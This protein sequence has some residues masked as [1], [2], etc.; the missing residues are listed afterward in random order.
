MMF[1]ITDL[2]ARQAKHPHDIFL[3]NLI[4]NHILAFAGLLGMASS[5]PWVMIITPTVSLS[6]LIYLVIRSRISLQ[7]DDWFVMC[8][9]QLCARRS[10]FFIAMLSIL[11]ALL[12][13]LLASVGWVLDDMKPGHWAIMGI[14]L[15]PTLISVLVL[16]VME[17]DAQHKAR[18]G[19]L[20]QWLVDKYPNPEA[21]TV[22]VIDD[23]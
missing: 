7:K 8:H 19:Q 13:I 20:P 11:I 12:L 1:E 15:L 22:K 4:V 17:Q 6:S 23:E 3:I 10:K 18:T 5:M 14:T 21:K 2:Q 16:I 9:W